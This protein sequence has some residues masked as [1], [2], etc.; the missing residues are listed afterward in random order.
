MRL[1]SKEPKAG[2]RKRRVRDS[3]S[4]YICI[5]AAKGGKAEERMKNLHAGAVV[6]AVLQGP[7]PRVMRP[8]IPNGTASVL[9]ISQKWS[10]KGQIRHRSV[11]SPVLPVSQW[12]SAHRHLSPSSTNAHLPKRSRRL[13]NHTTRGFF[14]V[15]SFFRILV[16]SLRHLHA[17]LR[18]TMA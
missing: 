16:V 17:D 8:A 11:A 2:S 7:M 18:L 4:I 5:W 9:K 3:T 6:H 12:L 14:E 15:C 13:R 1:L 10:R